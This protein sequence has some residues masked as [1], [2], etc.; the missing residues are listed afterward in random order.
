MLYFSVNNKFCQKIRVY[1]R[2]ALFCVLGSF[3][4]SNV[5]RHAT[6]FLSFMV[7]LSS[8]CALSLHSYLCIVLYIMLVLYGISYITL[9]LFGATHHTPQMERAA[10]RQEGVRYLLEVVRQDSLLPSVQYAV[11]CGWL[12]LT[13]SGHRYIQWNF[14]NLDTNGGRRKC[15]C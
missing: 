14:S 2:I 3:L 12:G 7:M 11:L 15:H 13:Y 4:P 1:V 10:L 6:P 9:A 5:I 8:M